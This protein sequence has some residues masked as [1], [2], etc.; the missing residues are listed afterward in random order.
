M[1]RSG[2]QPT[3]PVEPRLVVRVRS[4]PSQRGFSR[5]R[6]AHSPGAKLPRP[7]RIVRP[8]GYDTV[9]GV[10]LSPDSLNGKTGIAV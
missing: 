7:P 1:K 9:A 8:N 4:H 2:G 5:Y 10:Q 3:P 6:V